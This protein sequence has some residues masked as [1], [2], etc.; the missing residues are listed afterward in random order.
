MILVDLRRFLNL[1][2]F[3]ATAALLMVLLDV[4]CAR[5]AVV[6]NEVLYDPAGADGGGEFV[7]IVNTG[8]DPVSLGNIV[9]EFANGAVGDV[10]EVRWRATAAEVLGSGHRYL[11][12]DRG[13][14]EAVAADA[15]V[16]LGLQNGPDAV[17][18][19]RGQEVLDLLGYGA[20]E[21][22]ALFEGRPHAGAVGGRSLARRPDGV[23]TDHN[24]L[25]WHAAEEP[26]P[27]RPNVE[28]W[29]YRL[30]DYQLTPPARSLAGEQFELLV[31]WRNDGLDLYPSVTGLLHDVHGAVLG[32]F[33]LAE[34]APGAL[35]HGAVV[36]SSS[37][38]G[39]VELHLALPRPGEG[40][41]LRMRAGSAWTGP[42]PVRFSEVMAAPAAGGPEWIELEVP[43]DAVDLDLDRWSFADDGGGRRALPSRVLARG[44]RLVLTA[45]EDGLAAWIRDLQAADVPWPCATADLSLFVDESPDGCPVLNNTASDGDPWADRLVIH[46]PQGVIVDWVAW[47][48]EYPSPGTGRSLERI[49]GSVMMDLSRAWR[50]STAAVGSTPGCPNSVN[51]PVSGSGLSASPT[52]FA[53]GGTSLVFRLD[54]GE[55]AWD[56]CVLDLDTRVVRSLGGDGLGPGPR[57]VV[58]N[59]TTDD[60]TAVAA[61]PWLVLLR[62]RDAAG[63]ILR[64]NRIVV[65]RG[66]ERP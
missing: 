62:T 18:L 65:V 9:L 57:T 36:W 17:R 52:V 3:P 56:L 21:Q 55:T 7:E 46:D 4:T 50:S 20:L 26:T 23:D 34:S 40:D 32:G 28:R 8:P 58:W 51:A 48:G 24:D 66:L 27:G 53:D 41:T 35:V 16:A 1:L 25:D 64:R 12:V 29:S 54:R 44:D 14:D 22:E 30:E 39:N 59:G 63:R 60:G 61:G 5:A 11:I 37:A 13:W 38:E 31:S 45:D 2:L 43:R 6:L 49:D 15:V 42:A 10:W 19:R 33:T 47:G